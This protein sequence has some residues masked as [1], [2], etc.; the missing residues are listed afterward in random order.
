MGH[1][2]AALKAGGIEVNV[3]DELEA[4]LRPELRLD[5]EPIVG[6]DLGRVEV[7]VERRLRTHRR[8]DAS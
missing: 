4:A 3:T 6:I 2:E 1:E 8:R 7:I 5:A